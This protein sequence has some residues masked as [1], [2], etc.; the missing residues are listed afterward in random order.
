MEAQKLSDYTQVLTDE[1]LAVFLKGM[2]KFDRSFC[3]LMASSNEFTIRLEVK[4]DKG[5]LVHCRVYN[6]DIERPKH[7][8]KPKAG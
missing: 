6:D 2:A 4:G 8:G 3:S 5:K 1:S 7:K